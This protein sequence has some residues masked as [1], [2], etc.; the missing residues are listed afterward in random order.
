MSDQVTA[1]DVRD[2][3]RLAI[4]RLEVEAY[5]HGLRNG[6]PKGRL[7]AGHFIPHGGIPEPVGAQHHAAREEVAWL[8]DQMNADEVTVSVKTIVEYEYEDDPV[9]DAIAVS[10]I[11][12]WEPQP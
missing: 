3:L 5:Q 2:A 11:V 8:L 10:R 1:P 12:G 9:G 4:Q 7:R 6:R